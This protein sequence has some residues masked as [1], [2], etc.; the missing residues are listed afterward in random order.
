M[1]D[2]DWQHLLKKYQ[3]IVKPKFTVLEIGASNKS[4]TKDLSLYCQ[5]LIGVEYYKKRLPKN[6]N[7]IRY[8]LGDWQKL[9]QIIKPNSVDL[10]ISS[11]TIEHIPDDSEAL[12]QLYRVLK[13]GSYA[14]LTTPNRKRLSRFLIELF[15]SEKKFPNWEHVREYTEIDLIK[16]IK[17]SDFK[18]FIIEPIIFG[19]HFW[20]IRICTTKVPLIFKKYANCWEITLKK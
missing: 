16:L 9:N 12:R 7:N 13:S 6:N 10:A 1:K 5:N 8:L 14:I 15:T 19:F 17:K 18:N 20:K 11:H 2:Y 4:R 3:Q